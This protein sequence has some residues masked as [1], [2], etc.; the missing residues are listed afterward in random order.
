MYDALDSDCLA[1]CIAELRTKIAIQ[2]N[3][4]VF[5]L[6][7]LYEGS[8]KYFVLFV[9]DRTTLEVFK[10]HCVD[11]ASHGGKVIGVGENEEAGGFCF[12]FELP[13]DFGPDFN[14][15]C[16]ANLGCMNALIG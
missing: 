2:P 16:E 3:Q 6:H 13:A 9:E 8:S 12:L 11:V 4:R 15:L 10:S 5:E 14:Q 7:S 1:N